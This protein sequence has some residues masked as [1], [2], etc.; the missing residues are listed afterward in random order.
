MAL[1]SL[2]HDSVQNTSA[3]VMGFLHKK[4]QMPRANQHFLRRSPLNR[5]L[6]PKG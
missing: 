3:I 1:K 4:K 2:I 5:I 6:N